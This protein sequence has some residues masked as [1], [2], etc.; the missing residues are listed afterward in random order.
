MKVEIIINSKTLLAL[1]AMVYNSI[2]DWE[3]NDVNHNMHELS[4]QLKR[5]INENTTQKI[6]KST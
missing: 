6:I 5:H 4:E 3:N 2:G 1:Y